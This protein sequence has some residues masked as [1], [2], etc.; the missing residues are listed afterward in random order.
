M[1]VRNSVY[2]INNKKYFNI[3]KIIWIN[4]LIIINYYQA[5]E[6]G[7]TEFVNKLFIKHLFDK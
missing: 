2:S 3:E 5:F 7:E 4:Y 6:E 1:Y